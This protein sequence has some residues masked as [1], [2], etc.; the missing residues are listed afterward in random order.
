M[1]RPNILI[2]DDEPHTVQLIRFCLRTLPANLL[3]ASDGAAAFEVM[4][5]QTV[6]LVLLDVHMK[7]IDGL[8]TIKAMTAEPALRGIPVILM[9]AGGEAGIEEAGLALGVQA[10]FRKPFSPVAL[11]TKIQELLKC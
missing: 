2:V 5:Q 7:G 11:R 6:D 1:S 3:S 10:F 8:M 4:R 9:S